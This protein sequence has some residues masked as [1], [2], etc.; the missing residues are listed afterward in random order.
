[1]SNSGICLKAQRAA[2]IATVFAVVFCSLECSAFARGSISSRVRRMATA[3][4]QQVITSLQQEIDQARKTLQQAESQVTLTASELQT[5]RSNLLRAKEI[6]EQNER[7]EREHVRS[8]HDVEE[9]IL[10]NQAADS[11]YAKAMAALEKAEAE[12]GNQLRQALHLPPADGNSAA[13]DRLSLQ[14]KLTSEQRERLKTSDAYQKAVASVTL[15]AEQVRTVRHELFAQNPDWKKA[16]ADRQK[17]DQSAHTAEQSQHKAGKQAA[18]DRAEM[19][20]ASQVAA[21]AREVIADAESQLRLLG[22]AP[23]PAPTAKK[24]ANSK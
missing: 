10:A 6:V 19:Q 22:V 3:Q 15:A 21:Y 2:V 17:A 11:A 8:L 14:A 4:R 24:T 13:P 1:M 12:Q 9:T 18:A 20:N 7:E 16:F 23:K 5:A